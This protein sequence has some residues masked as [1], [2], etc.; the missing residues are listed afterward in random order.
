MICGSVFGCKSESIDK[1]I[2]YIQ[3]NVNIS[4]CFFSRYLTYSGYGGGVIYVD[5]GSYSMNVNYSM[6]YNCACSYKG[7]AILFNS[8][9]SCLR[10]ICSYRCSASSCFFADLVATKVNLLEYVSISNSY[11]IS[12]GVCSI[13]IDYGNQKVEN[14]NSSMNNA[15]HGSGIGISSPSVFTSLYCTFSNNK[16]FDGICITFHTYNSGSI[17]MAYSNIVHNDSPK[18]G[19]VYCY[20]EGQKMM[21]YCCLQNNMNFLFYVWDGSLVVTFSYIYHSSNSISTQKKLT[22]SFNTLSSVMTYQIRHFKSYYCNA[23]YPVTELLPTRTLYVITTPKPTP[24]RSFGEQSPKKPTP[25]RSLFPIH[26]PFD[27][28][29]PERTNQRS[30][31][32]DF[33]ERTPSKT[34]KNTKNSVVENKSNSVF[35]YSTVGLLMILSYN[36]GTQKKKN[37]SSSSSTDKRNN[38]EVKEGKK[39]HNRNNYDDYIPNPYVF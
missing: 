34:K 35:I 11:P 5:R 14:T 39:D 24:Y 25:P 37:D 23:L 31:P 18:I 15:H 13:Y 2:S 29:P 20:G 28:H 30:F 4:N 36:F 3:M 6:F 10:M 32:A 27:T 1:G 8:V 22:A 12:Y 16:V 17:F 26:T 7:G 21:K 19:V 33:V 38:R 9:N